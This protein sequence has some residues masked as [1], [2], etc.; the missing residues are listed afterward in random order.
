MIDKNLATT[1]MH[2]NLLCM[3]PFR[4]YLITKSEP[5]L[6][7]SQIIF[8]GSQDGSNHILELII[9]P[10]LTIL[11][12]SCNQMN[13]LCKVTSRQAQTSVPILKRNDGS[14]SIRS[15]SIEHDF[16]KK[17]RGQADPYNLNVT[18]Y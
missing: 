12:L 5:G 8:M 18:P 9:F 7:R 1:L 6:Y 15:R 17:P 11:H 13:N 14:A 10:V 2:R 16:I 4:G 3:C